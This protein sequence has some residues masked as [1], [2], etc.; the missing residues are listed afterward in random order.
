[1]N[2]SNFL[3]NRE[4][5]HIG[6]VVTDINDSKR[7][8]LNEGFKLLI[9]PKLDIIQNVYCCLLTFSN[10]TPIELIAPNSIGTNKLQSRISRGNGIDHIC[11]NSVN[12]KSDYDLVIKNKLMIPIQEIVFANVFNAK[13]CF[14]MTRTGI[15]IELMQPST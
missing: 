10:Q 15:I 7:K 6:Y 2:L 3:Y 1:M 14:F 9:E 12:I 4:I 11:Y 8:W 5:H 13:I